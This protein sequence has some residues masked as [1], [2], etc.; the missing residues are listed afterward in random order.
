MRATLPVLW[1]HSPTSE[2]P[3]VLDDYGRPPQPEPVTVQIWAYG[4]D[5][6]ATS[7]PREGTS[8][9]VNT[10]PT[11]YLVTDPG[12]T[13][14]DEMTVHGRRYHVEGEPA[15]WQSPTTGRVVGVEVA[16]RKVAG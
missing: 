12:I 13:P 7:E 2:E 4:F 5:P 14:G 6:G 11:I 9:R 1:H 15:V 8:R 16:L 10:E 3:S